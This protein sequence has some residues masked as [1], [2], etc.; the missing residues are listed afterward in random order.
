VIGGWTLGAVMD[1]QSGAPFSVTSGYGTLNRAARSYYN[2]ADTM[3][4][5]S[6]LFNAVS[7]RMTGNGPIMVPASAINPADGTGAI[8]AIDETPFSG[9]IFYNPPAG[10]LGTLQRRMFDGPWTFDLDLNLL[11]EIKIS[12]RHSVELRMMAINALNHATFYSGDQNI[13][14]P[15]FGLVGSSFFGSRVVEFGL[16]YRY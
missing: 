3:L 11:K 13:N 2:D 10:T 4:Q 16:T 9:E 7:F 5:G 14:S 15:T 12:D 1:W 8:S 6:A